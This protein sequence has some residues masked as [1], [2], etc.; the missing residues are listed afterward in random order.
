M[1]GWDWLANWVGCGC[2]FRHAAKLT[3]KARNPIPSF[4][5]L[6][7]LVD[8]GFSV[9]S[10]GAIAQPCFTSIL[11]TNFV[12]TMSNFG[13]DRNPYGRII[14]EVREDQHLTLQNM[15]DSLGLSG[16]KTYQRYET[17]ETRPT[18]EFLEATAQIFR[19]S[20]AEMLNYRKGPVFNQCQQANTFGRGNAYY[21]T[22]TKL[23]AALESNV[24]SLE[25]RGKHLEEEVAFL[26]GELQHARK[27]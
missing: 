25:A 1:T 6:G 3:T 16:P 20:L 13:N 4:I 26:R 11:P 18:L 15:A 10:K 22:N 8:L 9:I 14:K 27:A 12:D 19:M 23:V 2:S 7:V 5:V 17:G 21:E 24:K